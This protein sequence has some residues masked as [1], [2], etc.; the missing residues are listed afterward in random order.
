MTPPLRSALCAICDRTPTRR[1]SEIHPRRQLAGRL[2]AE[3]EVGDLEPFAGRGGRSALRLAG[4]GEALHEGVAEEIVR[5]ALRPGR[6]VASA[7]GLG[8]G[9]VVGLEAWQLLRIGRSN[10]DG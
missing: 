10:D 3:V 6:R 2:G 1:L 9:A 7:G 4:G 8:R 5:V